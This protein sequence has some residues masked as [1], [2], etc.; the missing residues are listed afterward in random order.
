MTNSTINQKIQ[1]WRLK[2]FNQK[3]NATIELL[4]RHWK[5]LLRANAIIA[6]PLFIIGTGLILFYFNVFVQQITFQ[7]TDDVGSLFFQLFIYLFIGGLLYGTALLSMVLVTLEVIRLSKEEPENIDKLSLIFRNVRKQFLPFV[8]IMIAFVFLIFIGNFL[9]AL[10]SIPLAALTLGIGSIL[11]FPIQLGFQ[12]IAYG[13]LY[14][15]LPM[16]YFENQSFSVNFYKSK[17]YFKSHFWQTAG[18]YLGSKGIQ[19]VLVTGLS[20]PLFIALLSFIIQSLNSQA[21]DIGLMAE[22]KWIFN[23]FMIILFLYLLLNLA[24]QIF[25]IITS[26]VQYLSLKEEEEGEHVFEQIATFESVGQ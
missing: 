22:N 18:M 9:I 20:L 15:L 3:L 5:P 7:T 14:I 4:K 21:G 25:H 11:L 26:A 17:E 6:G 8:G 2:T 19:F 12:L 10:L 23:V 1:Y 13:F 16:A 24:S